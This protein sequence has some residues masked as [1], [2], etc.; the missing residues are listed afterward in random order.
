MEVRKY[1]DRYT[2]YDPNKWVWSPG[3]NSS[4]WNDH[5][6]ETRARRYPEEDLNPPD[7]YSAERDAEQFGF[8]EVTISDIFDL[9]WKGR[10]GCNV[11][12]GPPDYEG[13]LYYYDKDDEYDEPLVEYDYDS[14]SHQPPADTFVM[15]DRG[16]PKFRKEWIDIANITDVSYTWFKDNHLF[17]DTGIHWAYGNKVDKDNDPD[18]Y[19]NTMYGGDNYAKFIKTLR[20]FG[21]DD[22][23][24]KILDEMNVHFEALKN[25]DREEERHFY[26]GKTAEEYFADYLEEDDD[27]LCEEEA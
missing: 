5:Y 16:Y 27:D 7:F 23:A 2:K 13:H 20:K 26:P 8:S 15:F 22:L 9:K 3:E 6:M 14:N 11:E 17:K 21:K 1:F 24:Q 12:I 25:S 4:E 19:S 10:K 18:Y